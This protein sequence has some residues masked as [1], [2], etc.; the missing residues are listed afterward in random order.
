MNNFN[1][2][3]IWLILIKIKRKK[4]TKNFGTM[5]KRLV[6]NNKNKEEFQKQPNKIKKIKASFKF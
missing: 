2:E 4:S 1:L 6:N 3:L 5:N